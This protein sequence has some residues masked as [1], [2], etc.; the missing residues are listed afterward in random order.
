MLDNDEKLFVAYWEKNRDK[1]KNFLYQLA[2]GLPVGLVFALPV[3]V[4]VIFHD[5]YKAMIDISLSQIVVIIIGVIA[6]AVFFSIFRMRFR[7]EQQEQL[8]KELKFKE[9][10]DDAA[11]L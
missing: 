3:L 4:A 1:K 2:S 11:H 7:W 10:K 5:W 8:Y 6:V 9:Q